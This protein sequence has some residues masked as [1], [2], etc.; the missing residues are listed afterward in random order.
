[1]DPTHLLAAAGQVLP[2]EFPVC[3]LPLSGSLDQGITQVLEASGVCLVLF[4][5]WRQTGSPQT[6]RPGVSFLWSECPWQP[7]SFLP[8]LSVPGPFAVCLWGLFSG[9]TGPGRVG[10]LRLV[11]PFLLRLWKLP[12]KIPHPSQLQTITT[13]TIKERLDDSVGSSCCLSQIKNWKHS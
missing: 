1:M 7:P 11:E 12:R 9:E 13:T 2:K 10:L 8:L 4:Q 5:G 3:R 6:T